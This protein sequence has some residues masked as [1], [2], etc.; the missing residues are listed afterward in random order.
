MKLAMRPALANLIDDQVYIDQIKVSCSQ[1]SDYYGP[2]LLFRN[3]AI[4]RFS[5]DLSPVASMSTID[6]PSPNSGS[7]W[8]L[9]PENPRDSE[10]MHK[11]CSLNRLNIKSNYWKI[12]DATMNLTSIAVNSGTETPKVAISS[13]AQEKNLYLYLLGLENNYLTHTNTITLP[14]IH[15]MQW[16]PQHDEYVI[17]GNSKGYAHLVSIPNEEDLSASICKRFNHRKHL[18]GIDETANINQASISKMAFTKGGNLLTKYNNS[19]FLWDIRDCESQE[20]PKPL[21]IS[22]IA[23]LHNFDS[24]I[25]HATSTVAICGRF[26]VSLFDTRQPKFGVPASIVHQANRSKMGATIIKWSPENE[27]VFAAAHNDGVVRLWDVRQQDS[28]SSLDGH[29]G[30]KIISMEWNK[31]D[32]FT[33]GK[34]G[35]IVHWDLL[36]NDDGT[37]LSGACGLKEGL[38][39]V[40]F[41]PVKNSLQEKISQRQCGTVL[42]ASNSTIVGMASVEHNGDVKVLSVDSSSFLGVHTKIY[43]AVKVDFG[44]NKLYYSDQEVQQLMADSPKTL[45]D[46]QAQDAVDVTLPLS[47]SRSASKYEHPLHTMSNDTLTSDTEPCKLSINQYE[48]DSNVSGSD[49]E[50]HFVLADHFN[51]SAESV[52]TAVSQV[53]SPGSA[54]SGDSFGRARINDSVTS[55]DTASTIDEFDTLGHHHKHSS[56]NINDFTFLHHDK[57]QELVVHSTSQIALQ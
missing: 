5:P 47:I 27:F 40:H 32:L 38:S 56:F 37:P 12:P 31:G 46:E 13:G 23:G 2:T 53:S 26:G 49:D 1:M 35:N 17:T 20:K 21:T 51:E 11:T 19:L 24:P 16:V 55:I 48:V 29:L 54:A 8:L 43:D 45:V 44:T 9:T 28:Y 41:D 30:R 57:A 25:H 10:V 22:N 14:N 33:G 4:R 18:K 6:L 7:K 3:N 15:L 50:F 36:D 34:D 39:S 42:P 52:A